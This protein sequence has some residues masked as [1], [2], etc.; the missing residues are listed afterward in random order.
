MSIKN[1][2]FIVL[3][4]FCLFSV[5]AC[6]DKAEKRTKLIAQ[7]EHSQK[8]ALHCF[9]QNGKDETKCQKE[10]EKTKELKKELDKLNDIK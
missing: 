3:S 5:T 10:M 2:L 9:Y 7:I 6:E 1:S 4:V 8:E